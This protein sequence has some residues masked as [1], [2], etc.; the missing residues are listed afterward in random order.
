M[1]DTITNIL[2]YINHADI[3]DLK[4]LHEEL[5]SKSFTM[6]L[7]F[8][9]HS[10]G[11][12]G[13][14]MF[15]DMI[16]SYIIKDEHQK[17]ILVTTKEKLSYKDY[18]DYENIKNN[19]DKDAYDFIKWN[20]KPYWLP[21]ICIPYYKYTFTR[22]YGHKVRILMK[23]AALKNE[24][25]SDDMNYIM[26]GEYAELYYLRKTNKELFLECAFA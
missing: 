22:S 11:P 19:Y 25:Y 4:D 3:N 16:N 12:V 7:A 8:D 20:C 2:K 10:L 21:K 6:K 9:I 13:Y 14:L 26:K 23:K 15:R 17:S 24:L 1:E 18:Q 5:C